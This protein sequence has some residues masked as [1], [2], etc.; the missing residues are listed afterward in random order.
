MFEEI[1]LYDN[2]AVSARA[3][4]L[5]DGRWRVDLDVEARKLRADSLGNEREVPMNDLIDIGVFAPA[6]RGSREGRPLYLAKHRV[7]SGPQRFEIV[8]DSVPGRAGIDPWHRL[9]DRVTG[10]NVVAVRR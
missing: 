4:E 9:I 10:D 7:D 5:P 2:R 8:V 6:P 3:T 1:T